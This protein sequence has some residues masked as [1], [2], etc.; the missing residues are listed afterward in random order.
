VPLHSAAQNGDQALAE[1]LL[2]HGAD[3]TCE[4]VDGRSAAAVARTAGHEHLAAKLERWEP[5]LPL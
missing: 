5:P 3:P 4:T 2:R 1:L